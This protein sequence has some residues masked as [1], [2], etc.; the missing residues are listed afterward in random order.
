MAATSIF[1]IVIIAANARPATA[2]PAAIAS[3][4]T[5]GVICHDRPAALARRAAIADNGVPVAVGFG[6]IRSCDLKAECLAMLDRRPAIQA[7]ARDAQH[8]EVYG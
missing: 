7:H 6:L 2:P 4:S 3:V 8:G 1:C 5:V